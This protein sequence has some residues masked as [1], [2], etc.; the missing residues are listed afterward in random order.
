[1]SG[2]SSEAIADGAKRNLEPGSQ[3]LFD[4]LACFRAVSTANC[5]LKAVVTGGNH[6]KE[7]PQ[8]RWIKTLQ[9]NQKTSFKGTFHAFNF[10]QV[11]QTLPGRLPLPL[12]QAL[13]NG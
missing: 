2:F 6:P 4:G 12:Q 1:M 8:F 13:G 3:V 11:R 9:G 10:E 5:H 7:L